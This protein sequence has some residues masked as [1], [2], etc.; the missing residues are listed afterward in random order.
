MRPEPEP[1]P[2]L[3][4]AAILETGRAIASVQR[5]DGCIPAVPGGTADPWNHVEAAMALD[6]AGLRREA[7]RAYEWL[8]RTQRQD[9]SWAIAYRDG[10]AADLG[11][12]ANFCA[13]AATGAWHHH[14]A[15]GDLG[16]LRDLWPVVEGAVEFTLG[17]QAPG[18]EVFW[19]RDARG[20]P[21]PSA[22]LT[23]SSCIHLSLGC[24]LAIA[25]SLG[26]RR[27]GWDAALE[28]LALALAHR[29]GAFEPKD[30]WS[31]D[32]YYPVLGR[33]LEGEAAEQR[34]RE[35]WDR[36]VVPGLGVRCVA[37][38]PW[39]TAAETC[40]LVLALNALGWDE[41][42]RSLFDWIQPLRHEDG[43]YWTGV[44]FPEGEL[45]PEE[46]PTWTS[47]AVLL[48]ADA[49]RGESLT[50]GLFSEDFLETVA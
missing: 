8:A 2:P 50:S 9:G 20:R 26:H 33:A 11:A 22:L 42:A 10:R 41:E 29:P 44:T 3:S 30:R 12:D 39:I 34:I 24:A 46:R 15:T 13:Y 38:R 1:A 19:A 45:F 28:R 27:P 23:S 32:W 37:D 49:L 4:P 5:Q 17:L 16:F 40:E 18:G 31:M 14:L 43:S 48:A 25:A 36:F 47:G 6:V 35:G 21:W 7:E